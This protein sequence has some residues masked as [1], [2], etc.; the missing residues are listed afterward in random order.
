MKMVDSDY[1]ELSDLIGDVRDKVGVQ[2]LAIYRRSLA[3]DARVK[4]QDKRYRWDLVWAIPTIKRN[5]W[6]DQVYQ[7]LDDTHI[8]TALRRIIK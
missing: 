5:A 6:F 4:D 3:F 1:K 7:Y 8:D 2:R